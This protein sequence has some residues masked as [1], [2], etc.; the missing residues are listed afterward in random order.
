[1]SKAHLLR[2]APVI[3]FSLLAFWFL[4][5]IRGVF[6]PFIYGFLL[7]YLLDPLV[8]WL[9]AHNVS[10][11]LA[12]TLVYLFVGLV[13]ASI[14]LFALPA[15]LRD[16]NMIME[17]IPQY[18]DVLQETI[19]ELQ[20]GY[21]NVPLP[22]GIRQVIDQLIKDA[23]YLALDI[24]QGF[25]KGVL[26]LFSQVFNLVLAPILSFYFLLEF[27][28]IGQLLLEAVPVRHRA[29][30]AQIGSEINR[31][32]KRFIRGNLLVAFLVGCMAIAG[33]FLIGMD[34]PLLIGLL[35]GI[36]NFIPYFGAFISAIPAVLIGAL[37]S[38]WLALYVLGTMLLIQQIEGNIIS[39]KILGDSVG[40][41]PLLIILALLVAGQLWGLLGLVV[42]VPL[43]AVLRILVKHLYWHLV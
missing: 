17:A 21:N 13:G 24:V 43:A 9:E 34:Y 7:A 35:V 14:L 23:E 27:N 28:R 18:T 41:H 20:L 11:I 22:E 38:K 4:F 2:I 40:L 39:P 32:I 3:L 42:A 31:V 16:L 6:T 10:R 33:M 1:M 26:S 15:L 5:S 37:K 25:A 19:H 36:T 30:L 29:E 12:I 8:D